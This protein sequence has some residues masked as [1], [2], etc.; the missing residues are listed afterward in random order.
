M[1]RKT[2]SFAVC[3]LIFCAAFL[4]FSAAYAGD[5]E[6]MEHF[7]AGREY[8]KAGK[9]SSAASEFMSAQLQ[10][11]DPVLKSNALMDAAR[12]Y[13]KNKQY[14]SEFDCLERLVKEHLNRINF[15]NVV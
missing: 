13:R 12:A 14:G 1:T 15:T 7:K 8:E 3:A 2:V 9:F 5:Q 10:A 4:L 11:D 6:A